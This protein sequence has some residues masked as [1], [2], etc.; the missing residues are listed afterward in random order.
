MKGYHPFRIM[1]AFNILTRLG[2]IA[3][4][5]DVLKHMQIFGYSW[6]PSV[7]VHHVIEEI[8]IAKVVRRSGIIFGLSTFL[9]H[10]NHQ[11]FPSVDLHGHY[12]LVNVKKGDVL[13][14]VQVSV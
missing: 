12:D 10:G 8:N 3:R 6:K 11:F 7:T 1:K 9:V 2:I 5:I 4:S 14:I 13:V